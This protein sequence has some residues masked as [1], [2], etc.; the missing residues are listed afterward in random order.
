MLGYH[1]VIENYSFNKDVFMKK[2]HF[3]CFSLLISALAVLP[4]CEWPKGCCSNDH[5]SSCHVSEGRVEDSSE[6]L[7]TT[8][9]NP[10]I[11][12][13]EFDSYMGDILETQPQL[14]QIVQLMPEAETQIFDGMLN[15]RAIAM[16]IHNK[17]IDK[18]AEYQK[19]RAKMMDFVDRSLNIKFFQKEHPV[20][21]TKAEIRKFYDENKGTMRDLELSPAGVRTDIIIFDSKAD[22]QPFYDKVK[23]NKADFEKIAKEGN[24]PIKNAGLINE[25]SFD[26]EKPILDKVATIKR[27]PSVETVEL[28]DGKVAVIK[29][30]AK[31]EAKYVPYEQ[32]EAGLEN[33][34]KNQKSVEALTKEIEKLKKEFNITINKEY[35]ERK[36]K[37]G[38]STQIMPDQKEIMEA[39]QSAA[40]A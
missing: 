22:A 35:F 16:D 4:Q 32:V 38:A 25:Q 17:G 9:D 10:L 18:S 2:Q 36:K 39:M 27:F 5:T 15:E 6:V 29:A 34:L 14:K 40:A 13:K 33:Y 28:A 37:S 31:E 12:V 24:L 21:I 7:A 3:F 11:T 19:E 20:T 30:Y 1:F 23:G 26:V 8:G